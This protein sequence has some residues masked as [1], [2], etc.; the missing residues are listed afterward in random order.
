MKREK[1]RKLSICEGKLG[2]VRLKVIIEGMKDRENMKVSWLMVP[3]NWILEV[4]L[5][6]GRSWKE[7]RQ[8]S[9]CRMDAWKWYYGVSTDTLYQISEWKACRLTSW[10]SYLSQEV[11]ESWFNI[12]FI[13]TKTSGSQAPQDSKMVQILPAFQSCLGCH[14]PRKTGVRGTIRLSQ[15]PLYLQV[16][17]PVFCPGC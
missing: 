3:C 1:T 12:G 13:G 7:R 14:F 16:F 2:W 6:D 4:S 17:Q 10:S 5:E 8:W 11:V 9:E 15:L